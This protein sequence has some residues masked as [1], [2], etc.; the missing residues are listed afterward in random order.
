MARAFWR[1]AIR[2]FKPAEIHGLSV[3]DT[4]TLRKGRNKF[5]ANVRQ[6]YR[7]STSSWRLGIYLMIDQSIDVTQA[8]NSLSRLLLMSRTRILFGLILLEGWMLL[9]GLIVI[10]LWSLVPILGSCT[11]LDRRFGLLVKHQ[12]RVASFRVG[13]LTICL[14]PVAMVTSADLI[15]V[16]GGLKS[17]ITMA[18]PSGQLLRK[19]PIFLWMWEI[20]SGFCS[21]ELLGGW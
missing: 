19:A 12:S 17:P 20:S 11:G 15:R 13:N 5:T 9:T 8:P 14:M 4:F 21:A 1:L 6:L 18:K 10:A 7:R 16:D 3:D 2:I